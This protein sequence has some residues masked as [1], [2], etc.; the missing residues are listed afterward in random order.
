MKILNIIAVIIL[1]TS[2]A[3][4]SGGKNQIN[5]GP[6]IAEPNIDLSDCD[7]IPAPEQSGIAVYYCEEFN[8]IVT[9]PID[10]EDD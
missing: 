10:N 2:V 9:T 6:T 1:F 3:I 8:M 5:G 7:R 4:A